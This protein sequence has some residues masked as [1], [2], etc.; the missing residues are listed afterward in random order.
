MCCRFPGRVSCT[1]CSATQ[2]DA[3]MRRVTTCSR[4]DLPSKSLLD[5]TPSVPRWGCRQ[6]RHSI[7]DPVVTSLPRRTSALHV[8]N[9]TLAELGAS[10]ASIK[11]VRFSTISCFSLNIIGYRRP[12]TRPAAQRSVICALHSCRRVKR[13]TKRGQNKTRTRG[14]CKCHMVPGCK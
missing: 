11:R 9:A 7:G 6:W 8:G 13:C 4:S 14:H 3:S 2:P 10:R 5:S 1:A 12:R